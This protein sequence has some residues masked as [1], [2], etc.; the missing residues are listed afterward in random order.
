MKGDELSCRR[1]LGL[2]Y[3][4]Y[5]GRGAVF[6]SSERVPVEVFVPEG[7]PSCEAALEKVR[8]ALSP[9]SKGVELIELRV[10]R[11]GKSSAPAHPTVK[12]GGSTISGIP[13]GKA[14]WRGLSR[15]SLLD[16]AALG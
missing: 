9:A 14:L 10:S 6:K 3:C 7:C 16:G 12:V 5:G 1:S 4:E 2:T 15:Q 13:E 11:G 8:T